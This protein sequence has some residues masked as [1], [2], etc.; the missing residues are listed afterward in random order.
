MAVHIGIGLFTGQV[1]PGSKRT[2]V[3]EY[4]EIVDLVRLAE[5]LGFDSAWVSEHHGSGDGY[6]P[7]LLPTLAAFAAATERIRLGTG[8]LL[9]PLHHPLRLAEDA[10]TVDL[11]S[12]GR[13][14]LG[15]GLAWREEEFRMFG[16]PFGE[17]VRRTTETIEI[18]RRAWTGQRF[19]Y[20]GKVFSLDRVQVTPPPAQP[21][22][23]PIWLGG[24]V[25]ASI[26]RAGRLADGYIRTRGGQVDRMRADLAT[27]EAAAREAGR[28]PSALAF[29]QLQNTFVWEDGDAWEVARQTVPNQLGI[30]GGWDEG[31]DTPERGFVLS[32]PD[33]ETMRR[34]TPTGTPQE[35]IRMLRPLVEAFAERREFHLIVRLHYPGM[36]FDTASRA[37][38]LFGE[39]VLPALRGA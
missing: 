6:M 1:P 10:A 3:Q 4:R 12:G 33:E 23:P 19:S 14:I 28:D 32:P 15:L 30:Y 37:I 35:V 21:G 20:E 8:V 26:R 38:E 9:T 25:E 13:L 24:S 31:G 7:S 18:L 11:I 5:A 34:L 39:Q 29:A 17:R 22:G 27:T 2:F 36:D 16:V